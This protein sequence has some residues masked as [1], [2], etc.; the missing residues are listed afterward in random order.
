MNIFLFFARSSTDQC[1]CGACGH[2]PEGSGDRAH[3]D[4][5][6]DGRHCG[7][8][9]EGRGFDGVLCGGFYP[10]ELADDEEII[11]Q[12]D[13]GV[14][15]CDEDEIELSALEGGRKEEPFADK[16]HSGRE[17]NEAKQADEQGEGEEWRAFVKARYGV[18]GDA[19][20]AATDF[21]DDEEARKG[22]GK[23]ANGVKEGSGKTPFGEGLKGEEHVTGVGDC[24]ISEQAFEVFLR[25]CGQVA[26]AHCDDACPHERGLGVARFPATGHGE[27]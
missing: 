20:F 5:E 6:D 8:G 16:T 24:G 10:V 11:I 18:D 22:H 3:C 26:Q 27:G 2:V 15:G 13:R 9:D 7:D 14:D 25:E 12:G 19:V 23:V 1:A 17:A 4:Y 21:T